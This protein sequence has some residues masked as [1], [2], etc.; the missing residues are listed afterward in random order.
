MENKIKKTY[1]ELY[2]AV[3]AN[4]I[5]E[6]IKNTRIEKGC[7]GR[8]STEEKEKLR[9]V[10]ISVSAKK[11]PKCGGKRHGSGRGKKGWYKGF[12]CD[13]SYELAWVIYNLEHE[14]KFK[15]NSD[16][17]DYV[18]NNEKHLFYPDFINEEGE[19]IEIKGYKTKQVQEKIKQFPLKITVLYRKNLN[20]EFEYVE[21]KYGK[22]FIYLYDDKKYVKF[23]EK[24]NSAL[25]IKNKSGLCK[26]CYV[27]K[28]RGSKIK[29]EK[30][31]KKI[32]SCLN[33]GK[34]IEKN[35]TGLCKN[36]YEQKNKF[37]IDKIELEKLI[38]EYS[39]E[40]IGKMFGVSGS[41]VKKRALKLKI[42]LENRIGYWNKVYS[43]IV[44]SKKKIKYCKD[45]GSKLSFKNKSGYCSKCSY[46]HNF[47][48]VNGE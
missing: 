36:C 22:N 2:G 35:K 37:Q 7:S 4:E 27:E 28:L 5:K 16:G 18:F 26:G 25:N 17:F 29:N 9:R 30:R 24:C 12:F 23:C 8:A 13:S 10:K 15:R 48:I 32:Y 47:K 33:C 45:C 39:Y 6:R 46:E 3:R 20:K 11:N 42:K 44:Q 34:I 40:K 21:N 1:E 31:I 41:A 43:K 38:K 14:N 19:Y